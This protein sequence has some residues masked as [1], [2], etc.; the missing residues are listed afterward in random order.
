MNSA[1]FPFTGNH[2]HPLPVKQ[3]FPPHPA[4]CS[5]L[6]A[7]IQ[8]NAR[9][10]NETGDTPT[11]AQPAEKHRQSGDISA[12]ATRHTPHATRIPHPAS[13]IPAFP[14]SRIP[15]FPHSRIPA[16]PHSRFPAF[17]LS[18]FP[19]FPLATCPVSRTCLAALPVLFHFFPCTHPF[20]PI[21]SPTHPVNRT[22]PGKP[23]RQRHTC[24]AGN[25]L[26]KCHDCPKS[27]S[28]GRIIVFIHES[29]TRFFRPVPFVRL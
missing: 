22:L 15:A 21:P 11:T 10:G 28:S 1:P 7:S 26:Q 24:P 19:A 16:F 13:R 23:Y 2:L 25:G 18:R 4:P 9:S 8:K 5:L 20:H 14:H 27:P 3:A 29:G 6:P 12:H 17:P